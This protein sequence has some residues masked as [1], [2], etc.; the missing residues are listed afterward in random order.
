MFSFCVNNL[1]LPTK[2]AY[3]NRQMFKAFPPV[4]T[5]LKILRKTYTR[6]CVCRLSSTESPWS[7]GSNLR[8]RGGDAY[9]SN[10]QSRKLY[11]FSFCLLT[12]STFL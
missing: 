3:F 7:I 2:S 11:C 10:F 5:Q 6:D 9:G 4:H 12:H 1:A 8:M